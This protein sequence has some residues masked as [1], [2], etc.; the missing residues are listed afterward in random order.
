M[1]AQLNEAAELAGIE[2]VVTNSRQ[3]LDV[4][5]SKLT[6]QGETPK[7]LISWDMDTTITFDSNGFM[8]NP[9]VKMTILIMGM[10]QDNGDQYKLETAELMGEYFKKFVRNLN[11]ILLPFSRSG[12]IPVS[13]V[14]YK[15]VPMYGRGQH[16]GVIGRVTAIAQV[17]NC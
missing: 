1:I 9:R 7:M 13:D 16:S 17:D 11:T 12:T 3:E 6:R 4:Q 10:A 8:D 5:I 14:G 15:L 2:M